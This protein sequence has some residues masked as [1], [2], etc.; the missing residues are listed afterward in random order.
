MSLEFALDDTG[1]DREDALVGMSF[2]V[3]KD[4][5]DWQSADGEAASTKVGTLGCLTGCGAQPHQSLQG[6]SGEH[7]LARARRHRTLAVCRRRGCFFQGSCYLAVTGLGRCLCI[8]RDRSVPE[9]SSRSRSF[10]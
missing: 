5:E 2:H 9:L 7:E 6:C 4:A 1:G 10:L 3:P 8:R